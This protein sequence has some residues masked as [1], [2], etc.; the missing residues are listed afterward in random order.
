MAALSLPGVVLEAGAFY[1]ERRAEEPGAV[2]AWAL[3]L[4]GRARA[5]VPLRAAKPWAAARAATAL[6][7]EARACSDEL[8]RQRLRAAARAVI[9]P[10]SVRSAEQGMSVHAALPLALALVREAAA[11][12]LAMQPYEV[13]LLGAALLLR[14]QLAEM[15]TG[16][17][18]TLTAGLGAAL[19]AAA[20]LPV[21]VITVNDYLAERDAAKL[22]PLY[23]FLGLSVGVVLTG[24]ALG[25]RRAAYASDI[26]YVTGKEV[27]FDYLKDKVAC[28]PGRNALQL[29]VAGWV[30]AGAA[31][32]AKLAQ[33]ATLLRGLHFAIVDEADSIFIDEARTP[34]I[35]SVSAEAED[36]A[37]VRTYAQALDLARHLTPQL[38][39]RLRAAAREI[40]LTPEGRDAVAERCEGLGL[41]WQMRRSRE[42]L[43]TQ[44]LRALHLFQRDLQYVVKDDEVQIVDEQTGR[45]LTGRKWEQGLHQ[46]IES[47]EG[48]PLSDRVR[49]VARITY[50]RFFRR[51]LRLAGMTG[52]AREVRAELWRVYGLLTVPVPSHRPPQRR[53]L[54]PLVRASEEGKWQAVC[55]AVLALQA[56]GRPVLV[57]TRSVQASLRVSDAL[58]KRGIVHRVLNA[59]QDAEEALLVE[60]A[61]VAGTVT[62]ATNMAGRGTDI[63]LGPGVH[64]A[65]GLHV[66]LTEFHESRRVDRQL[67]GR[68]ARQG[69]PGSAQA[70]VSVQDEL[71]RHHGGLAATLLGR[72]LPAQG[73][74]AGQAWPLRVLLASAR[75]RGQGYTERQH[76][77]ERAAATRRDQ[78]IE[79]LLS[80]SGRN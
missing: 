53:V 40:E 12:S 19:A 49:T 74:A 41:A 1:D 51:Y 29:R 64:A 58:A 17:G 54:P 30:G 28:G 70:I 43:A 15:A 31:S 62:V 22:A 50:Q 8:L 23:H 35:L 59:L 56:Q 9:N 63:V 20:G 69:D 71:L 6:A 78:Q 26:T 2:D 44:A 36:E 27:V 13:Q 66:I 65:G 77:R 39:W 37:G 75:R 57:G 48:L 33:P 55:D 21:H 47:K 14:G 16:E 52:T 60:T 10:R 68:A 18:K 38:H 45:A 80:F 76:A 3:G 32:N 7:S 61:G 73:A 46:L 5:A 72:L 11:R 25:A 67:F 4:I 34:L 42:H 79:G 24:M